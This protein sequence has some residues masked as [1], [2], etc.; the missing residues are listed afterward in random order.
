MYS[1]EWWDAVG[2]KIVS[3]RSPSLTSSSASGLAELS[4][5]QLRGSGRSERLELHA[6]SIA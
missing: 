5:R 6:H 2:A 3:E 1:G 4:R